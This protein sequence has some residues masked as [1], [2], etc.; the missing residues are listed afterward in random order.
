MSGYKTLAVATAHLLE[1][2]LKRTER[3]TILA[4]V[5][6]KDGV[7]TMDI[8]NAFKTSRQNAYGSMTALEKA[9]LTRQEICYDKDRKIRVGYWYATPYAKDVLSNFVSSLQPS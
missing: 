8:A 9:R 7:E 4:Y 3:I 2:G 5:A 1:A 6:A